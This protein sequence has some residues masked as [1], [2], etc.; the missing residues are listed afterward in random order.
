MGVISG[1]TVPLRRFNKDMADA[2]ITME[3]RFYQTSFGKLR[4][5]LH[6]NLPAGVHALIVQMEQWSLR[7]GYPIRTAKLPYLGGGDKRIIEWLNG[8]DC[9]NPRANGKITT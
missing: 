6:F 2:T 5:H 1:S 3:V 8:L 9:K 7:P 4:F